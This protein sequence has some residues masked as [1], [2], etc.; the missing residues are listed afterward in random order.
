[1]EMALAM[2]EAAQRVLKTWWHGH[3]LGFG[4]GISQGYA[5]LSH[6]RFCRAYVVGPSAPV[7]TR[8]HM[9]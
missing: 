4:V 5:T 8:Q 7:K 2:R 1:M 9:D 6:I 3:D